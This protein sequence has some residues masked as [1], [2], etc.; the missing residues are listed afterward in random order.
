MAK[1]KKLTLQQSVDSV[2]AKCDEFM[3]TY[4]DAKANL[5]PALGPD[6]A[7]YIEAMGLCMVGNLVFVSLSSLDKVSTQCAKHFLD[8]ASRQ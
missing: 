8:G 5:S 7:Q 2:G 6:A 4:L 3:K 1:E